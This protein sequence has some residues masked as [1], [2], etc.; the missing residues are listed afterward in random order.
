[1]RDELDI[2]KNIE[3]IYDSASSFK[4]LKDFERV[5]DELGLYVYKNW[6]DGE[7]VEGPHISRHWVECA[8]MWAKE[9]MPDP[10]GGKRLVDYD[11]I[12]K[13][14][15][16]HLIEP[17]KI[18]K[19]GDIRPGTQK[20]KL[21]HKPVWVVTISM[22]KTL[23]GNIHAGY[24]RDLETQ[25]GTDDKAFVAPSAQDADMDNIEAGGGANL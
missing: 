3:T 14:E 25:L 24:I 8:F 11:C 10:D 20:G 9:D 13:Y 2:I 7:L 16:T 19:P 23:I 4:V 12:V 15:K 1:M 21:D 18:E 5:L 22:P 17:R 6:I